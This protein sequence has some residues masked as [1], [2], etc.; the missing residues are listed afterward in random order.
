MIVN[1]K[2]DTLIRDIETTEVFNAIM[3]L[4]E[5]SKN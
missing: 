5:K 2:S 4:I 1:K 3:E